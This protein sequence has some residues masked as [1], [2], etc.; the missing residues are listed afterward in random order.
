MF[1][2]VI[3][4]FFL[5]WPEPKSVLCS[6]CSQKTCG[7]RLDLLTSP[8]GASAAEVISIKC[9]V[10]NVPGASP[11]PG[12]TFGSAYNTVGLSLNLRI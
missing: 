3:F 5:F 10:R 11:S 7:L 12:L 2:A 8:Y 9:H 6:L 1:Y 4:I